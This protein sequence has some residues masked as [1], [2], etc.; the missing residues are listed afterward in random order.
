MKYLIGVMVLALATAGCGVTRDMNDVP[1]E[2]H[3]TRSPMV[4]PLAK[5]SRGVQ[6]IIVSPFDI[7]AT[8]T[9]VSGERDDF[10]QALL[11]GSLEGVCNMVVRMLAGVT[12][13]L[14]FPVVSHSDP[15]YQKPLGQRATPS[16]PDVVP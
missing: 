1:A 7:P 3:W 8:I 2:D 9:R 14:T 15:M 11:A 5:V 16:Y 13:V 10:G 4:V 6:N 12:E